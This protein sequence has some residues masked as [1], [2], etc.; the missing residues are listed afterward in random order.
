VSAPGRFDPNVERGADNLAQSC[1]QVS[2]GERVKLLSFR[3]DDV[4][5][6]IEAGLARAGAIVERTRLDHLADAPERVADEVAVALEGSTASVYVGAPDKVQISFSAIRTAKRATNRHIH[7]PR[8]DQRILAQSGRADPDLLTII[9]DRLI[10]RLR[11]NAKIHVASPTGTALDIALPSQ[12]IVISCNG[13]PP[14]GEVDN[15]PSGFVFT[16]PLSVSGTLVVDRGAVSSLLEIPAAKLRRTPVSLAISGGRVTGVTCEDAPIAEA[17]EGFLA[18]HPNAPR[19]GLV[20]LPT[21]YLVRSEIGLEYQDALLPG[22]VL[23]L[24]YTAREQT[25]ATFDA[26]VQLR[27][28]GRKQDVSIDGHAIVHAGRLDD[29]LVEGIDPFR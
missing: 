27:L 11:P 24:G 28:L 26:P 5:D 1:L 3:A 17:F 29:A 18:A 14:L 8:A 19:V 23:S 25:K 7:I 12:P 20:N 9:N 6:P 2:S 22:V 10:A 13:R 4:A 21:N 15:L 16:H